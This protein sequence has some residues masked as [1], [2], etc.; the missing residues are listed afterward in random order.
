MIIL[1]VLERKTFHFH[2]SSEIYGFGECFRRA[3][4]YPRILPLFFTSDHGVNISGYLDPEIK[5]KKIKTRKHLTWSEENLNTQVAKLKFVGT[6]HPWLYYLEEK[7][8]QLKKNQVG[9]IFYP[10]HRAPGFIFDGL[11]DSESIRYLLDLPEQYQPVHVSL[12]MHDLGSEREE[13]FLSAGFKI[14]TLGETNERKFHEKFFSLISGYR[15][16]FSESWG[17][18]VP[19]LI[20]C[21]VPTQIIPRKITILESSHNKKVHSKEF[22]MELRRAEEIF[23][24]FPTQITSDQIQYA[25]KVLGVKLRKTRLQLSLIAYGQMFKLGLPWFIRLL[26]KTVPHKITAGKNQ[27]SA[28]KKRIS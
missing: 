17:S 16:A 18:Q 9:S 2:W 20:M 25:N 12:H 5:T 14:V 8:E 22:E 19:F 27:K 4:K 21:G 23:S 28:N 11:D 10:L 6:Q 13:L 26:I 1:S 15:Y 7:K 24:E 3:A